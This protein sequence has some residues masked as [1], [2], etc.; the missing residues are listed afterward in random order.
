MLI[1]KNKNVRICNLLIIAFLFTGCSAN[2]YSSPKFDLDKKIL[3]NAKQILK[4][5]E[6][7][8]NDTNQKK[9][10]NVGILLNRKSFTVSTNLGRNKLLLPAQGNLSTF[11]KNDQDRYL[12]LMC[13]NDVDCKVKLTKYNSIYYLLHELYH[14]INSD[15]YRQ[16]ETTAFVK[17]PN[18]RSKIMSFD[19]E[20][21]SE[22]V[23]VKYLSIYEPQILEEY[24]SLFTNILMKK[25]V[26]L[27]NVI[28]KKDWDN[29]K[30]TDFQ[31]INN[32][33]LYFFLHAYE[34]IDERSLEELLFD[35]N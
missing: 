4:N 28:I 33:K 7:N 30:L 2:K 14:I 19:E 35:I 20:I 31:E 10:Q 16:K 11:I 21:R 12:N 1:S 24:K 25:N 27:D 3:S 23:V 34:H 22:S 6:R 18:G 17:N 29:F 8:L 5:V 15:K 26:N 32:T 9:L 13:N